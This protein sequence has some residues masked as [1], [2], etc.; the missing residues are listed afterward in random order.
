MIFEYIS[1]QVKAQTGSTMVMAEVPT[2]PV[3]MAEVRDARIRK[4]RSNLMKSF[5]EVN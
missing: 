3:E 4:K 2:E 1:I 5:S